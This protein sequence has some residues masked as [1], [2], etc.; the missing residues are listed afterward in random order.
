M[1][2]KS[3]NVR[4]EVLLSPDQYQAVLKEAEADGYIV[5]TPELETMGSV[6]EYIRDVLSI[7]VPH[8]ADTPKLKRGTYRRPPSINKIRVALRKQGY[9]GTKEQE[10][11]VVREIQDIAKKDDSPLEQIVTQ[12][13]NAEFGVGDE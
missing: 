11:G 5:V 1:P 8:F 13:L 9:R 4:V 12:W 10:A 3:E 7:H 6:A 2:R